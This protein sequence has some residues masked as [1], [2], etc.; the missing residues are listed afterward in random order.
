MIKQNIRNNSVLSMKT[1]ELWNL[2]RYDYP[3]CTMLVVLQKLQYNFS[4]TVTKC[5]VDSEIDDTP[6]FS[7]IIT[8]I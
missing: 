8:S 6:Y 7:L 5:Q 3:K 4:L 1:S 2:K